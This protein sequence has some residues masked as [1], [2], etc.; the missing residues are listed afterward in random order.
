[1][2]YQLNVVG[3][4]LI[5]NSSFIKIKVLIPSSRLNGLPAQPAALTFHDFNIIRAFIIEHINL[6]FTDLLSIQNQ[7]RTEINYHTNSIFK[8]EL[9]LSKRHAK[10]NFKFYQLAMNW[11]HSSMV[12]AEM[13][14]TLIH[15]VALGKVAG[16][17]CRP[18]SKVPVACVQDSAT[19]SGLVT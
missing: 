16:S 10:D 17:T 12:A 11:A 4:S 18:G 6:E 15:S 13:V 8:F 7:F 14:L 9:L 5:F 2:A 3:E 19:N 1:M